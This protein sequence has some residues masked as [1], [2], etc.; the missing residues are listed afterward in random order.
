MLS[1][2]KDAEVQLFLVNG[3]AKL[4]PA[5]FEEVLIAD[6]VDPTRRW[7][8]RRVRSAGSVIAKK[9]LVRIDLVELIQPVNG[10]IIPFSLDP[11][12]N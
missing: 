6:F 1:I 12:T 2:G 10:F 8:V 5:V 7:V 9:R 4:I 11:G 3:L